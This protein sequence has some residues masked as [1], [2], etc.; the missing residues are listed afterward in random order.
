MEICLLWQ[1]ASYPPRAHDP[2]LTAWTCL[3]DQ[4]P[5]DTASLA[6]TFGHR[7]AFNQGNMS[8]SDMCHFWVK[9]FEEVGPRV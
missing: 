4:G 6:S 1:M 8:R 3:W 5:Q 9:V 2:F 7:L